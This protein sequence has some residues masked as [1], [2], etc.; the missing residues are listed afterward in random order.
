M[1]EAKLDFAKSQHF[2]QLF[3]PKMLDAELDFAGRQ[4]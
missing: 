1:L 2:F 4:S 3:N